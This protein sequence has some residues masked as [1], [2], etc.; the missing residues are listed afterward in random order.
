MYVCGGSRCNGFPGESGE[1]VSG[2]TEE[3]EAVS[4]GL[5]E[6]MDTLPHA[7]RYK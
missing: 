7:T 3:R 1:G 5:S 4:V 6:T 2:R